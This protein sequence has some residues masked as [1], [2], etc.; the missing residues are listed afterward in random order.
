LNWCNTQV[1]SSF[2]PLFSFKKNV[3]ISHY[4]LMS[5]MHFSLKMCPCNVCGKLQE[6]LSFDTTT[7]IYFKRL[8][9]WRFFLFQLSFGFWN[10][11]S[12]W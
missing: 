6:M 9:I 12:L 1:Q 2:H 3:K 5:M 11:N 8:I 4:R 7:L 10:L